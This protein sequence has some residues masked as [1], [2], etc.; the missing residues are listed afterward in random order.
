[1]YSE[2]GAFSLFY[3]ELVHFTV[4]HRPRE[5]TVRLVYPRTRQRNQCCFIHLSA[6]AQMLKV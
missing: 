1:M 5:P 6:N 3:C 4:D 2:S